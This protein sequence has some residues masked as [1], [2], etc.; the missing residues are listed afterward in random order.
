MVELSTSTEPY[1]DI[2]LDTQLKQQRSSSCPG[3]GSTNARQRITVAQHRFGSQ[4]SSNWSNDICTSLG[5][6]ANFFFGK[7]Q[8]SVV[9]G[10]WKQAKSVAKRNQH[11]M[12][13]GRRQQQI[14]KPLKENK[15][16][17][18]YGPFRLCGDCNF[19]PKYWIRPT[20]KTWC[21]YQSNQAR[22]SCK[23][24]TLH[25]CGHRVIRQGKRVCMLLPRQRHKNVFDRVKGLTLSPTTKD[26]F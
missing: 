9:D 25:S 2:T 11:D 19:S 13:C 10:P 22:G 15:H 16:W 20:Q 7:R 5:I 8:D 1:H 17:I 24:T 3:I 26:T 14:I 21:S 23:M 12:H 4:Q 6:D 18:L